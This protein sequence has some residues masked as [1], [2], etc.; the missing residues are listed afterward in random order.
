VIILFAFA[1]LLGSGHHTSDVHLTTKTRR[2][3]IE[4]KISNV[5]EIITGDC[6]VTAFVLLFENM[7]M[8]LLHNQTNELLGT[9]MFFDHGFRF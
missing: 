2:P 4:R 8:A 3:A 5:Q 6:V 7:A 9:N 1:A